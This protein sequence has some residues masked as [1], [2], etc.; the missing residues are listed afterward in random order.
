MVSPT[1]KKVLPH[2]NLF[3][4]LV[5]SL[6]LSANRA[7]LAYDLNEQLDLDSVVPGQEELPL[8][9]SSPNIAP[10]SAGS[11]FDS[12]PT[13][14]RGQDDF[15]ANNNNNDINSNNDYYQSG[16]KGRKVSQ[17]KKLFSSEAEILQSVPPPIALANYFGSAFPA[18]SYPI[19]ENTVRFSSHPMPSISSQQLNLISDRIKRSPGSRGKSSSYLTSLPLENVCE[20]ESRWVFK[21]SKVLK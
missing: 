9:I 16:S 8:Q 2:V 14:S 13:F 6:T 5:F 19:L 20:S 10:H 11:S 12:R 1:L 18:V 17:N 4:W 21:V 15:G 3:M 7:D